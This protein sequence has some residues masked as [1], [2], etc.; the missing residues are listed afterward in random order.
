[1]PDDRVPDDQATRDRAPWATILAVAA[2]AAGWWWYG[3]G[4]YLVPH[5]RRPGAPLNDLLDPTRPVGHLLGWAGTAMMVL[6]MGY[7]LRKR[8]RCLQRLGPLRHWLQA[9]IFLGLL[10]PLL[11]TFHSAFRVG[12]LVAISYWCMILTMLS[13]VFG[14]YVY[15]RIPSSAIGGRASLAELAAQANQLDTSVAETL[16]AGRQ[17]L[18]TEASE[19]GWDPSARGW[20]A[21]GAVLLHDLRRPLRRWRLS[22]K[23]RRATGLS[24]TQVR[25]AVSLAQRR[26]TIEYRTAAAEAM[27]QVL[28]YWHILHRPFV[29]IMFLIAALHIGVAWWLG[30]RGI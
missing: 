18:L 25:K 2:T 22:R 13:G 4:Y 14:R 21:V 28:H 19:R 27:E 26:E 16:G 3:A 29:W 24:R 7:S 5:D 6:L 20:G 12:G 8:L 17:G 9:H 23:L 11:V 15:V 1:M 10:G 30:Y